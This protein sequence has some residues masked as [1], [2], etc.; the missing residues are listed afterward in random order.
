VQVVVVVVFMLVRQQE[1][2]QPAVAAQVE[3]L[4][5]QT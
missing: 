1:V 2:A 4:Q 3:Q 5:V